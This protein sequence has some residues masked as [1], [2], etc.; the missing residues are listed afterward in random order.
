MRSESV[1]VASCEGAPRCAYS[2]SGHMPRASAIQTRAQR[3]RETACFTRIGDVR[4]A[5]HEAAQR[6]PRAAIRVPDRKRQHRE[7]RLAGARGD[8]NVVDR[9]IGAFGE[10]HRELNST[11][12]QI[13]NQPFAKR[14]L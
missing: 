11:W 7:P 2:R 4:E 8:G 3:S 10:L 5:H 9:A 12:R 14:L 1:L 13:D 6:A